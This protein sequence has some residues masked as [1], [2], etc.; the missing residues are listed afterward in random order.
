MRTPLA[1][2][3][4][5]IAVAVALFGLARPA[6]AL[7]RLA[8]DPVGASDT[9]HAAAVHGDSPG[10]Q[11]WYCTP[12]GCAGARG[13]SGS[14]ALGFAATTLAAVWISRRRSADRC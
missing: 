11:R 5:L 4:T 3:I 2:A 1:S 6:R 8:A 10:S 14:T 12:T 9:E 7:P 13:S